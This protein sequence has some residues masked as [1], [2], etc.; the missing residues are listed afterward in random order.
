MKVRVR[1]RMRVGDRI[2]AQVQNRVW[3]LVRVWVRMRVWV[4][5]RVRMRAQGQARI[6]EGING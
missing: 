5:F 3:D 1:I 4:R 2:W 6:W